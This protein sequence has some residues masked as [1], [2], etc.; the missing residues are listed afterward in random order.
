[1]EKT[2][3]INEY[4]MIADE[5]GRVLDVIG[6]EKNFILKLTGKLLSSL[7]PSSYFQ[8]AM[9]FLLAVKQQ[10]VVV[11]WELYLKEDS[12]HI[13]VLFSGIFVKDNQIVIIV[14]YPFER[15]KLLLPENIKLNRKHWEGLLNN[16]FQEKKATLSSKSKNDN[17]LDGFYQQ[18]SQ[19]NNQLVNLQRQLVKNNKELEETKERF[20]IT[21]AGIADAV[22]SIDS[23]EQVEFINPVALQ[24]LEKKEEQIL[25]RFFWDIFQVTGKNNEKQEFVRKS[26]STYGF[27]K[28]EDFTLMVN[29]EKSIPIDFNLSFIDRNKEKSGAVLIF[30]DISERKKK[31]KKLNHF[32]SIDMLTGIYNRRMGLELLEKQIKVTQR[33][34]SFLTI[35]FLDIDGLKSVNDQYGHQEGD[36]LL[37]TIVKIINDNIRKSDTFC[38]MG[39]DEFLTIFP[40]SREEDAEEVWQRILISFNNMNQVKEFPYP[41]QVSHGIVEC[42]KGCFEEGEEIDGLIELADKRMYKEKEKHIK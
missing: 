38:R 23:R 13:M 35:C 12:N 21:L 32:A 7:V 20:R 22:I 29:G 6:R 27:C 11:G 4:L 19:M 5:Q 10:K 1:M 42:K 31:E 8:E 28:G 30:R 41:I 39:G 17:R 33:R 40:D 9:N 2:K 34:K 26:L 36:R 16:Y 37:K 14:Q 24:L 15:I 18:Y 25:G 3:N